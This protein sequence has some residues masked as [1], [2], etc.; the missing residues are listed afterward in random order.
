MSTAKASTDERDQLWTRLRHALAGLRPGLR[1]QGD[2]EA[3]VEPAYG[4]SAIARARMG[5]VTARIESSLKHAWARSAEA[6]VSMAVMAVEVDRF[7]EWHLCA[8]RDT[9]EA[10]MAR[11]VE[12]A[13]G[14]L[15]RAQDLC[16]RHG[17]QGLIVV[18]PDYP[19]LMAR[20]LSR[21]L[22]RTV[23][24][25]AIPHRESHA[26]V[27]TVGVGLAGIN[28][29]GKYDSVLFE[30]AR[31]ALAR[32]RRLGIDRAEVRDLRPRQQGHKHA[33]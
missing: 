6:K 25:L 7:R 16:L 26:G 13:E 28:P 5:G 32:A 9:I 23:R 21:T 31:D 27:V 4:I 3:R 11:I 20:Q 19:F 15:P 17:R 24:A 14:L 18:L 10:G 8:D 12:A 30:E 33:A 1:R 29:Q 2:E 22:S